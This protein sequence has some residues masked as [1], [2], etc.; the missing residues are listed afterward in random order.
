[1][2]TAFNIILR[3]PRLEAILI[4]IF[5]GITRCDDIAQG[6]LMAKRQ[7]ASAVP[8]V[9]RLI[10]TNEEEGRR[11]LRAEGLTALERL[12]E[13]VQAVIAAAREQSDEH[14]VDADT[15]VIV[16]GITGRDG[17]FHARSML[18]YGT[19]VVG[20]VTPGKGGQ[21]RRRAFRC[22]TR[23]GSR[24]RD[25]GATCRDLRAGPLR[26]RG[27]SG[28]RP[29]PGCALIVCITEGIPVLEMLELL[30]RRA[31]ARARV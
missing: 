1:M 16:Q 30:P 23:S 11:I 22:S 9:I 28:R 5:G 12:S 8:L 15:R 29:T 10:G 18:D 3:N 20:G 27:A 14:P 4:N 31:R 17:S 25:R 21:E 2:L 24:R 19:R 7:P 13:A 26:R 6:I